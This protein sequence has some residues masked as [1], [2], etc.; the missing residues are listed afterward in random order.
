MLTPTTAARLPTMG[1]PV[2]CHPDEV[3]DAESDAAIAP[4]MD[5]SK[6]PVAPVRWIYPFL[7]RRWDGGA[8]KIAGTV[9]RGRRGGGLPGRPLPG[10]APGLI[11]LWRESD[12]LALVSD[13][14]YLIDSA[15]LKAAAA[16]RGERPAPGLGL[17]PRQGEGVGSQARGAGAAGRLRRA[18]RA[19]ARREPARDAGTRGREALS[20]AA[21]SARCHSFRLSMIG[22]YASAAL[23]CAASLLVGRALLSIAGRNSVVVVG[24]GGRPR[25]DPHRDRRAGARAGAWHDRDRRAGGAAGDCWSCSPQSSP[26]GRSADAVAETPLRLGAAGG[27]RRRRGALDPVR[28]ERALGTARGRLQQRPRPAPGLGGVAAQWL[29]PGAGGGLPAR[30]AR[31]RRRHRRCAGDR[32]GAGLRRRA[33]RDRRAHR[34]DGARRRCRDLGAGRRVLAAILVATSYLAA[35]YFAQAAFKE[36]AE[37]LFVLAV[38][39]GLHDLDRRR[40]ENG[41]ILTRSAASAADGRGSRCPTWRSP[42]GSSSPTASPGSPGRSRSSPSGA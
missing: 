19:A 37:A 11:G 3:A 9:E 2:Y 14:V 15:R 8:V 32:P 24:A 13:V 10:H 21:R 30:A 38:A 7:L 4:Y 41:H 5:L 1:A 42:A 26:T 39:V 35:S 22:T 12:R 6:L 18:R 28:G 20:G 34:L 36:T 25:R 33:L 23:I 27:D 29:R 31:A 16:G 40:A 17:G